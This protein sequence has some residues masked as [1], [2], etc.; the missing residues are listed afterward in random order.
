MLLASPH[1]SLADPTFQSSSPYSSFHTHDKVGPRLSLEPEGR[2]WHTHDTSF[3]DRFF[4]ALTACRRP[5]RFRPTR[6]RTPSSR[7]WKVTTVRVAS[8]GRNRT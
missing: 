4:L 1:L 6:N 8:G 7:G 3:F 5:R 2:V